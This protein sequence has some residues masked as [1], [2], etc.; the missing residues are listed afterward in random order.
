MTIA[1]SRV[2]PVSKSTTCMGT[3]ADFAAGSLVK[4]M[5]SSEF[6]AATAYCRE[7]T[8]S[9]TPSAESLTGISFHPFDSD[10]FL[11]CCRTCIAPP[12]QGAPL[13]IS[14]NEK[15]LLVRADQMNLVGR[16]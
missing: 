11:L 9:K 2:N 4:E 13:R 10:T 8:K 6:C 3:L 1:G 14:T 5:P 12:Q 16:S 7:K 15:C